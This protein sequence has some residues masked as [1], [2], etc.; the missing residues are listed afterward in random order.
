MQHE[1]ML[2]ILPEW[3]RG[4]I[5]QFYALKNLCI[6][7]EFSIWFR[8]SV[9]TD[10]CLKTGFEVAIYILKVLDAYVTM[11]AILTFPAH[12]TIQIVS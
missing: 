11:I 3:G 10:F 1:Y 5:F 7:L 2:G 8:R 6:F 9:E 12:Q 4:T